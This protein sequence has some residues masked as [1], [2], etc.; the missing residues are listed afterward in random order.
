MKKIR[1]L[2]SFGFRLLAPQAIEDIL[3]EWYEQRKRFPTRLMQLNEGQVTARYLGSKPV[4]SWEF[5]LRDETVPGAY[6]E[7]GGT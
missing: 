7:F 1:W 5:T 6:I 3:N 4:E 2:F